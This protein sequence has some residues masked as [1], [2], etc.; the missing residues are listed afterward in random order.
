MN[1]PTKH[2][3]SGVRCPQCGLINPN[4]IPSCETCGAILPLF[5]ETSAPNAPA[6]ANWNEIG[7]L[8]RRIDDVTASKSPNAQTEPAG[9]RRWADSRPR[10]D[11][12]GR[13]IIMESPHQERPDFDWYKFFTK[14]IWL[15]LALP[16]VLVIAVIICL[17]RLTTPSSLFYMFFMS[18][19]LNPMR[20]QE[21]EMIPVRY[22]RIRD[23][24]E[25]EWLARVKGDFHLGNIATDDLVSLRGK[26]RGGT[27]C[28]TSGYNHR[29]RSRI[30][31]RGSNLAPHHRLPPLRLRGAGPARGSRNY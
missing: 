24:D 15:V 19:A 20:R 25:V 6:Q 2:N 3:G 13:V 31:I 18:A 7:G 11:L 17:L 14:I 27:L 28:V 9:H 4:I 1:S 12:N 8:P 29:T 21:R 23:D 5:A 16:V 26:W 10:G 22:M 30:A